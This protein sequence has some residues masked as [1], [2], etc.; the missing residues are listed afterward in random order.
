MAESSG[1]AKTT[2]KRSS[3]EDLYFG[4]TR[5]KIE[6]E[7]K[8]QVEFDRKFTYRVLLPN[9]SNLVITL[10][11]PDE[12]MAVADFIRTVKRK[13]DKEEID[14]GSRSIK[15]GSQMYLEDTMGN[16]MQDGKVIP[17]GPSNKQI[18]IVLQV[19][20]SSVPL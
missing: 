10:E 17:R 8:K 19:V 20:S 6:F 12:E 5:R 2:R 1:T 13:C 11:E 9:G 3:I 7:A 14:D 18:I 16:R 15:W 4:Q